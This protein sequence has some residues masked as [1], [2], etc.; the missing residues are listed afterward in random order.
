MKLRPKLNHESPSEAPFSTVVESQMKFFISL[1]F[2]SPSLL[3][4]EPPKCGSVDLQVSFILVGVQIAH[5]PLLD[6]LSH[7]ARVGP[8]R[9][10]LLTRV[11]QK[12]THSLQVLPHHRRA[13]DRSTR[14]VLGQLKQQQRWCHTDYR[15]QFE[16]HWANLEA[17][18]KALV[19]SA[20]DLE[21]CPGRLLLRPQRLLMLRSEQ[22]QERHT[23]SNYKIDSRPKVKLG[24][25]GCHAQ[26]HMTSHIRYL[27]L[28]NR[29]M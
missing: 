10:R 14:R 9:R 11:T 21:C 2:V 19:S 6:T 18:E 1:V 26:I 13:A 17:W 3:A 16:E 20:I 24:A 8:V 4:L 23:K 29:R 12:G 28:W 27:R 22:E 25:S 7:Q 5:L 15:Q